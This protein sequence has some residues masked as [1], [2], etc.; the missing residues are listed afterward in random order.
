M[1]CVADVCITQSVTEV[2]NLKEFHF[3]FYYTACVSLII[4]I[5]FIITVK[6]TCAYIF[7]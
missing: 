4:Y 5:V 6:F 1:L 3:T 7:L 2:L